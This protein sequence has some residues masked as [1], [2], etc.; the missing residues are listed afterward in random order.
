MVGLNTASFVLRSLA[1]NSN[2]R[3]QFMYLE[4]IS[5]QNAIYD[6]I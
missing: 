3:N 4:Y 1:E 6:Q 5:P 2:V